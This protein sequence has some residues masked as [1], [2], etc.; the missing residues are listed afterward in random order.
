[1]LIFISGV[2]RQKFQLCRWDS[3]FVLFFF[4]LFFGRQFGL[5]P[6]GNECLSRLYIPRCKYILT[7]VAE[8]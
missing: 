1:M 2:F 6:G 8:D 7:A 3:F 4:F 5:L